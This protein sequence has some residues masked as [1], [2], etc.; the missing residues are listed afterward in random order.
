[1]RMRDLIDGILWW[2]LPESLFRKLPDRCE[3]CHG[4][5][6]GVRGNENLVNG[7]IMCDYC[8]AARDFGMLP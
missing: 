4:D 6:G 7:T 5:R 8:S 3:V 1:M 2:T